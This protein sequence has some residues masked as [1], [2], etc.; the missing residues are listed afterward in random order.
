MDLGNQGEYLFDV[1]LSL[2]SLQ[3]NGVSHTKYYFHA[4][5]GPFV[6]T[7]ISINLGFT[8]GHRWSYTVYSHLSVEV[9]RFPGPSSARFGG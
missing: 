6:I 9:R 2:R 7:R 1:A 3:R 5:F 4:V 8:V